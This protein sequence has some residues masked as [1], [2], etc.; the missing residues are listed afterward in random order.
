M[1]AE[2]EKKE[3][4]ACDTNSKDCFNCGNDNEWTTTPVLVK[5]P[6]SYIVDMENK[7][8]VLIAEEQ[9]HQYLKE[10]NEL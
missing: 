2:S 5:N 6:I 1:R 4:E 7:D 3:M 8:T 9:K 10:L